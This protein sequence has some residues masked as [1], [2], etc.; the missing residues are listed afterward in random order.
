MEQIMTGA[1][2]QKPSSHPR[3]AA[4]T[5]ADVMRTPMTTVNQYDHVAAAAYPGWTCNGTGTHVKPVRRSN[6]GARGPV[7][8]GGLDSVEIRLAGTAGPSGHLGQLDEPVQG[9][10]GGQ[11]VPLGVGVLVAGGHP[12]VADLHGPGLYR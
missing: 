9:A 8:L 5:V 7:G 4:D 6:W 2:A 10:R 11:G 12:P 3:A 1:S